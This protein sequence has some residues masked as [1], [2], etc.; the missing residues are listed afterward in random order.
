M[1]RNYDFVSIIP[2]FQGKASPFSP[3]IIFDMLPGYLLE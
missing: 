3:S 2:E 1:P